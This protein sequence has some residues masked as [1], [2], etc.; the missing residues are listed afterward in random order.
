M[1]TVVYDNWQT[2]NGPVSH[3]VTQLVTPAV[4][5]GGDPLSPCDLQHHSVLRQKGGLTLTALLL[6][7]L[8]WRIKEEQEQLSATGRRGL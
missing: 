5:V 4:V 7:E 6:R 1:R 2:R 3:T 8:N